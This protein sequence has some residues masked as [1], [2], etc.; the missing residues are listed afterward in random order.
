[1]FYE[2]KD[3]WNKRQPTRDY[4]WCTTPFPPMCL[5]MSAHRGKLPK[6]KKANRRHLP[7]LEHLRTAL[8]SHSYIFKYS[9]KADG[10]P[11]VS[12]PTFIICIV[13]IS[14][15]SPSLDVTLQTDPEIQRKTRQKSEKN[16]SS[17]LHFPW[18]KKI[19]QNT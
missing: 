11:T 8:V 3:Y 2:K 4:L 17:P 5:F 19:L 16:I 6:L 9:R 12:S 7:Y 18:R 10:T 1:M 14:T 13:V 15:H